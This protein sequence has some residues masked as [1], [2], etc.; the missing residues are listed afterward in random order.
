MQKEGKGGEKAVCTGKKDT[1]ETG[2]AETRPKNQALFLRH[3][4]HAEA[5]LE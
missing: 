5:W 2:G 3:A 1:K 4:P